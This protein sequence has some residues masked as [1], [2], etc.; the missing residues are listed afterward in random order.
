MSRSVSFGAKQY[1][2]QSY[3]WGNTVGGMV[4]FGVI[5]HDSCY[6][7]GIV[8]TRDHSFPKSSC[9]HPLGPLRTLNPFFL[10]IH[11]VVHFQ[12]FTIPH[13]INLTNVYCIQFIWHCAQLRGHNSQRKR[14]SPCSHGVL[15][16]KGSGH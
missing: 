8:S 7:E 4:D 9:S 14:L 15:Q 12:P 5:E 2:T 3:F 10:V 1:K 13:P 6:R 11:F 16:S